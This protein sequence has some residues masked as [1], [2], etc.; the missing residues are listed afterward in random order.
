MFNLFGKKSER[1]RRYIH[2][3]YA[4]EHYVL[5][6]N[7]DVPAISQVAT[8]R[9][10]LT[11][12]PIARAYRL[13]TRHD[14]DALV[15]R[16]KPHDLY[17]MSESC[18]A[19]A[20]R[21]RRDGTE[22]MAQ[23]ATLTGLY[24][25]LAGL[26]AEGE[27]GVNRLWRRVENL[28]SRSV[29]IAAQRTEHNSPMAK[30]PPHLAGAQTKPLPRET[31]EVL[32]RRGMSEER[33]GE[34]DKKFDAEMAK[35]DQRLLQLYR[36]QRRLFAEVEK[37]SETISPS[38]IYGASMSAMNLFERVMSHAGRPIREGE[39]EVVAAG[40]SKFIDRL[41]DADETVLTAIETMSAN[42]LSVGSDDQLTVLGSKTTRVVVLGRVLSNR[43]AATAPLCAYDAQWLAM[44]LLSDLEKLTQ[45][46]LGEGDTTNRT[47]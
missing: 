5:A 40:M 31:I 28:M 19:E 4:L 41:Y 33:Y 9:A 35:M 15:T 30:S 6:H 44:T 38:G 3:F 25:G 17:A 32:K 7:A 13:P 16:I 24:F 43:L 27:R 8:Q 12:D 37:A 2:L 36:E 21:Y 34:I 22:R 20:A 39:P 11:L 26:V 1:H 42:S 14:P 46:E 45:L 23:G 29:D 18:F 47:S 10:I